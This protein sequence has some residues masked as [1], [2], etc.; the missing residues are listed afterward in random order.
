MTKYKGRSRDYPTE[1]EGRSGWG[2]EAK[3]EQDRAAGWQGKP[4]MNKIGA[5]SKKTEGGTPGHR[6]NGGPGR[7]QRRSS[8]HGPGPLSPPPA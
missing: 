8:H 3:D 6:N 2:W 7:V 4:G 1:A 5:D